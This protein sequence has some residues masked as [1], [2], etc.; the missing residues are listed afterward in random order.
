DVQSRLGDAA[1]ALVIV[2]LDPWR[3]IP[4]R[5]PH[6]AAAWGM[7]RDAL[8][9][10][11]EVASVQRVLASWG[12]ETIR[13]GRT[14]EV[15]HA[16]I[17]F[18]VDGRGNVAYATTGSAEEMVSLL[19]SLSTVALPAGPSLAAATASEAPLAKLLLG[20]LV[21]FLGSPGKTS[22]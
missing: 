22:E 10:S 2:T 4:S 5:L 3:D 11:G 12:V 8:V 16:P 17:T 9:V 19:G 1:P 13:D 18:L 6:I 20:R 7:G 21:D 15:T 14:G